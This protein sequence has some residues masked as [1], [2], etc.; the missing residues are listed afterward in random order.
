MVLIKTALLVTF[1][2]VNEHAKSHFSFSHNLILVIYVERGEDINN[3][4]FRSVD[5][6]NFS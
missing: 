3:R 2:K 5:K 6:I 4:F 1:F